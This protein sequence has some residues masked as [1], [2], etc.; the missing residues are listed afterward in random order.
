MAK[1]IQDVYKKYVGFGST[2]TAQKKD[3]T[4]AN[5]MKMMNDAKLITGKL[6]RTDIDL[7]FTKSKEKGKTALTFAQFQGALKQIA[8]IKYGEDSDEN[9]QKLITVL[10]SVAGPST[11]GATKVAKNKA[12][13]RLT[14]TSKYTGSHKER[15]NE[16]GKGRGIQGRKDTPDTSGYVTGYGDKG[17]Y[18]ET[19]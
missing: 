3:L 16:D 15:F 6:T 19:H 4:S 8:K 11:K 1:T 14:D 12:T 18:D 13:E 10:T 9:V 2:A 5:F 17:K 7:V